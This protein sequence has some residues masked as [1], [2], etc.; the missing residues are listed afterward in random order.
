LPGHFGVLFYVPSGGQNSREQDVETLNSACPL[1]STICGTA[2]IDRPAYRSGLHFVGSFPSAE[3]PP[4]GSTV[5]APQK[6]LL[7][8]R[9]QP[10]GYLAFCPLSLHLSFRQSLAYPYQLMLLPPTLP[11]C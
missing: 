3:E 1:C 10:G 5:N 6:S 2:L 9:L 11:P 8:S 7:L 4:L